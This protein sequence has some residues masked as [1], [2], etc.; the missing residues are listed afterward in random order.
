MTVIVLY[1]LYTIF[2]ADHWLR[3]AGDFY[4][5]LG[6]PPGADEKTIKSRFRRLQVPLELESARELPLIDIQSCDTPP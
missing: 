2:E 5:D 1:L 6:L 4:Q 3:Q